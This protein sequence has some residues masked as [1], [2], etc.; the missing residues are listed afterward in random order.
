[1]SSSSVLSTRERWRLPFLC[2]LLLLSGACALVYQTAWRRELRL[3]FGG[4]T[5]AT[6]AVLAVFMGGLGIGGAWWGRRAER[7]PNVLLL[8]ARLELAI[9]IGA[10]LTPFLLDAVRAL[11]VRTGG[12]LA[13]GTSGATLAQLLLTLLVLGVPCFLLGGNLPP[14]VKWI[15]VE[16]DRQRGGVA[17][18]YG[19]NTL[20]AVFGV[21]VSSFWSLETLGTR[22]TLW[23]AATVNL[24]IGVVSWL[25]ARR[26]DETDACAASREQPRPQQ[27]A[28]DRHSGAPLVVSAQVP[29][30]FVYAAA[31]ISGFTFFVIEMVWYRLLTPLL[32]GSVYSFDLVLAQAL[33]GMAVGGGLYRALIATRR[34]PASATTLAYIVAAQALALCLPWALGDY[35][36]VLAFHLEQWR[37]LGFAALVAGWSVCVAVMVLIPSILSGAQFPLLIGLLGEGRERVAHQLGLAYAANTA[38]AIAGSLLGGFVLLPWLTAPGCWRIM[39]LLTLALA[40]TRIVD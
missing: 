8:Y 1:M 40:F 24:T 21:L 14:A 7:H 4:A 22:A 33:F 36:A 37:N 9:A 25:V 3:I 15:E 17:T 12:V 19:C 29:S 20:G 28:T 13:L 35:L 38:G 30:S 27:A 39:I 11:Y 16:S 26:L 23:S 5:P 10:A 6:S 31:G 34:G 32:G 18:I 2:V